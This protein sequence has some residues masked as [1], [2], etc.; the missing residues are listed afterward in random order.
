MDVPRA[1]TIISTIAPSRAELRFSR[2]RYE[3]GYILPSCQKIVVETRRT[4]AAPIRE[5]DGAMAMKA[6][7]GT[8][9]GAS[10]SPPRR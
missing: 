6:N 9:D 7:P 8:S 4:I 2:R 10:G 5:E 1:N 3:R